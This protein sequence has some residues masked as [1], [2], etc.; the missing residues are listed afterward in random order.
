MANSPAKRYEPTYFDFDM[1]LVERVENAENVNFVNYTYNINNKGD[2]FIYQIDYT[3]SNY[4]NSY[5]DNLYYVGEDRLGEI[6]G[7]TIIAPKHAYTMTFSRYYSAIGEGDDLAFGAFAYTD[8]DEE[9]II[10]GDLGVGL[11]YAPI[12]PYERYE[13]FVDCSVKGLNQNKYYYN[14]ILNIVYDNVDYSI[15]VYNT[16]HDSRQGFYFTSREELDLTKLSYQET[17][18]TV[19]RRLNEGYIEPGLNVT[20][21]LI[22]LGV[23]VVSTGIFLA[24]YLPVK[25]KKKNEK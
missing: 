17:P 19:A 3:R 9:A 5:Y 25:A 11:T 8:F 18:V 10:E 23:A 6:F 15:V 21:L 24:I 12:Y 22:T 20:A 16:W 13:Y 4:N 7:N 2:G 14:T 1:S